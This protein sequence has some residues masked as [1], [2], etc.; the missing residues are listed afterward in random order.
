MARSRIVEVNY[1]EFKQALRK[2][3]DIGARIVPRDKDAWK[4][5]V[6]ENG[7]KEASFRAIGDSQYEGL[8]PV[9]ITEGDWAGYYMYTEQEE[10]SLKWE[11]S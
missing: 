6:K 10:A 5:W 3:T 1:Y 2:A 8:N 9:I 7:I 4:A 11:T